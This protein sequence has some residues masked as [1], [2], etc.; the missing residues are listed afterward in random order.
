[1]QDLRYEYIKKVGGGATCETFLIKHK[2]MDEYRIL[3][4]LPL[5]QQN[6]KFF[7]TEVEILKH[8]KGKG[9]PILYDL[10]VRD[11]S[12]LIIEEFADG[13]S[14]KHLLKENNTDILTATQCVIGVCNILSILH[15]NGFIYLDIK[16]EHIILC[17]DTPYLIDYGNCMASGSNDTA[18]ISEKFAAPE[19]F[20]GEPVGIYSDIYSIGVLLRYICTFYSDSG[21]INRHLKEIIETCMSPLPEERFSDIKYLIS[22]LE[23]CIKQKEN[24]PGSDFS[25]NHNPNFRF[26]DSA[27]YIYGMRKHVG[28]THLSLALADYLSETYG[29]TDYISENRKDSFISMMNNGILKCGRNGDLF[30]NNIR[31]KNSQ[32]NYIR[33]QETSQITITDCGCIPEEQQIIKQIDTTGTNILIISDA[34]P[35]HNRNSLYH[36][37]KEVCNLF[38]NNLIIAANFIDKTESAK[39]GNYIGKKLIRMP[40][41]DNPMRPTREARYFLKQIVRKIDFTKAGS[42]NRDT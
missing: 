8:I 9:I 24:F 38:G 39:I 17:Q 14:L 16:P 33:E 6:Q 37:L 32:W 7:D 27:I 20:H 36:R 23:S 34:A 5:S 15:R 4:K 1:M 41:F 31:V 25:N 13:K 12:L 2:D 11:D 22:A 40:V 3:K 28:C 29:T 30:Y 18:M 21:I 35:W 26:S 19:Q 10:A 42:I